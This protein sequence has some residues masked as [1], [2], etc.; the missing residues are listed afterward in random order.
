MDLD[1][2]IQRIGKLTPED[3]ARIREV[4]DRDGPAP[5]ERDGV[6][7]RPN[8]PYWWV[9]YTL[10]DGR[11]IRESTR[12]TDK[13]YALQ[14]L[15]IRKRDAANEALGIR[16]RSV[17]TFAELVDRW[18]ETPRAKAKRSAERDAWCSRQWKARLGE[19][20]IADLKPSHF[21]AYIRDRLAEGVFPATINRALALAKV[22]LNHAVE[23]GE[24]AESPLKRMKLLKEPPARRPHLSPLDEA[25]ILE[26]A[27]PEWVRFLIRFLLA[28]GCRLGEALAGTFGDVDVARGM[29]IIRTSKGGTSREVPL[30]DAILAE[31]RARRGL[32]GAPLIDR[33]DG[34][35]PTVH[36]AG[37]AW[38]RTLAKVARTYPDAAVAGLRLHDLRHVFAARCVA[39]GMTLFE[40]G[41]I[42]GHAS[43]SQ[44]T[45]RYPDVDP[46]RIAR[47]VRSLDTGGPG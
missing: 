12:S 1:K 6:F 8:S 16:P 25:R 46:A 44:V 20:R 34:K 40:L 14:L 17:M 41:R 35:A 47:I 26:L 33:G 2:L 9:S 21:E 24:L 43:A 42:L 31:L 45:Q 11:R 7:R 28:T 37:I 13:A 19:V 18:L 23:L 39:A 32:P 4:L 3:R 38:R 36:G 5:R 22:I 29:Y 10:P 27:D 15:A 30:T